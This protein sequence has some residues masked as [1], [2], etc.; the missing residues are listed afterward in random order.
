[1]EIEVKNQKPA[2]H[3][4]NGVMPFETIKSITGDGWAVIKNPEREDGTL[5]RGE[6]LFHSGDYQE[7]IK[8]WGTS[9]E[10]YVSIKY[11]GERDPNV[12]YIL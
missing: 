7:A 1:M 5:V 2:T 9:S 11:C 12:V 6:L 3:N 4:N 10:K 8:A